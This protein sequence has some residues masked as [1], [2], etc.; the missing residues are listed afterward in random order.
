M[1]ATQKAKQQIRELQNILELIET[2]ETEVICMGMTER[3]AAETGTVPPREFKETFEESKHL[4]NVNVNRWNELLK[5]ST[6]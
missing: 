1:T 3:L 5:S 2:F 6:L 4:L